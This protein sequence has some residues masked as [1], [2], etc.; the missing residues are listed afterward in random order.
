MK[1]VVDACVLFPTVLRELI[2][3]FA[4]TGAFEPLWSERILEEWR[5]AAQRRSAHDGMIAESEIAVLKTRFPDALASPSKDTADRLSLPDPDDIHVLAAAVDADAD[6]I[7]TLNLKDFPTRALSAE[8]IL[9]RDPDGVLLE[10]WH[11]HAETVEKVVADVL[12]KAQ[13]H[14][15]DTSNPRALLKRARVPRLGKAMYPR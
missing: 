9:R 5:R 3:G 8:G 7:L 12:S 2:L 6:A 15:I 10:G 1:M 4:D 13:T 14:R 11:A